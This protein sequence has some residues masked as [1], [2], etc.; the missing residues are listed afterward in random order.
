MAL[1]GRVNERVAPMQRE[2]FDGSKA[3]NGFSPL[4]KLNLRRTES[5]KA[6][7]AYR[8]QSGSQDPIRNDI[9][10]GHR[11]NLEAETT[12]PLGQKSGDFAFARNCR[13]EAGW[14]G[15]APLAGNAHCARTLPLARRLV[16]SKP[17]RDQALSAR[18]TGRIG[19][20][21]SG[22][23]SAETKTGLERFQTAAAPIRLK[24]ASD[25]VVEPIVHRRADYISRRRRRED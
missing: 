20:T 18:R 4:A 17:S 10:A 2:P 19:P 22:A 12:G 16:A 3:P 23:I 15:P 24:R 7:Y 6:R 5:G 8:W 25:S 21:L 11:A 14:P 13:D 1:Q 9:T